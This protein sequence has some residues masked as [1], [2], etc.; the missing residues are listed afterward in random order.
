MLPN[1]SIST[2]GGDKGRTSLMFGRRVGK[3]SARVCAYG[4]VD[5]L[6][7][8]LGTARALAGGIDPELA[9]AILGVQR[10]LV[11]LMTEL[12]TASE[13]FPK[14]ADKGIP[15]AGDAE[16][17][18]IET[19]IGALEAGREGLMEWQIPGSSPLNAA[20]NTARTICRRAERETVRLNSAEPLPRAFPIVYLN[21]LADLV[22]LWSCGH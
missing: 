16:L 6:S 4:G 21:R 20:L 9:E 14:L 11:S 5:E 17:A 13:D 15:L 3:D 2:K 22:F 8:A 10:T 18:E 7:A 19:R 12:A 1:M